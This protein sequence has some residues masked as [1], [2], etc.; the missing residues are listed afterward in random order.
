MTIERNKRK[1]RS[2]T[3]TSDSSDKTITLEI[4]RLVRHPIYNRVVRKRA[5]LMAHDEKNDAHIGDLVEIME[6]KPLSKKKR[7]RLSKIIKRAK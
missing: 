6:T 3:V 4:G 1:V 7:W 5:K 2:G